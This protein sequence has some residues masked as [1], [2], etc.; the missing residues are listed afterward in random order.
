MSHKSASSGKVR[1]SNLELYRVIVMLAIVAHH[2]VVNSG[3]LQLAYDAPMQAN[4][5]FALL[6]G[7]W[8]KAGINCFVLITGYFMCTSR[9]TLKKFVKLLL[10]I[11]FYRVT[12]FGIFL[13]TGYETFRLTDLVKAILPVTSLKDNFTGCYLVFFLCIPFLNSL[14]RNLNEKSHLRLLLLTLGM[15]TLLGSVPKFQLSMNYVSWF[16]VLYFIAAYVRLYPKKLFENT[17]LWGWLSAATVLVCGASVVVCAWL[18][19]RSG[20]PDLAYFFLVD[21]NR[22]L[23]V[24]VAVTSF[25]FFRSLKLSTSK[26][27][28]AMGSSTFGV[29]L[30]HA[31]SDTM[32]RWLWQDL[33]G[34]VKIFGTQWLI[35]HAVVSVIGIFVICC[36]ID[37]V[38]IRLLEKPVFKLW[39]RIEPGLV[40]KYQQVETAICRKLGI[41]E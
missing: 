35:P 33:L 40:R 19:A 38:R 34:N 13:L 7:A 21:S 41:E 37:A 10:E 31:H 22:V 29:L 20:R 2:Y 6:F 17:A 8:G 28:N 25:L 30:I 16:I 32:R 23:A 4:S 15:Y 9:I 26:L 1:S 14:L 27:I 24:A 39:D 36:A 12:I 11:L 18:G 3:V 5:L